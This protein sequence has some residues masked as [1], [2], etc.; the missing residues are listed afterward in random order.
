LLLLAGGCS[1]EDAHRVTFYSFGTL[2]ELV[3]WEADRRRVEGAAALLAGELERMQ[4]AWDPWRSDSE[5]ARVNRLL[6]AGEAFVADPATLG[7][8]RTALPHYHASGGLFDPAVGG[9]VQ[10]W[11]FH[12]EA[13]QLP[14][15][16]VLETWRA[17]PPSLGDIELQGIGL[18]GRH[19][20]LLLDFGG[21]AKG[22]AIDLLVARMQ[23]LGLGNLILNAGGDLRAVGRRGRRAWQVGI[24]HPRGNT[25]I[26]SVTIR[27]DESVF[28]SGDYE[29]F[30]LTAKQRYHHILD[31]R[32]G[33]PAR[34]TVAVTVI[35]T[36]A[37]TADAAATA[38]FVAG[39]RHWRE[40]AR[41]MGIHQ[42]MLIDSDGKAHL[43]EAMA[44]RLQLHFDPR[45]GL[46]L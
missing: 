31:P 30:F 21:F 11:G 35:H 17:D 19:P 23:R 42:A 10:A 13:P 25:V 26:A 36:S 46:Q 15:G 27:G 33:S 18:R 22:H 3:V 24:R 39:P 4:R 7:L 38:L 2:V 6:A 14:A 8:L 37:A 41:A 43:T 12:G 16:T 1:A 5:L 9:L 20:R 45:Q 29:R 40:V 44:E 28:T 32:T 34:G